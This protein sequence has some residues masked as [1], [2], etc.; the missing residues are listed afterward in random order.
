MTQTSAIVVLTG[1]GISRESGLGTFRDL[2][3]IWSRVRVEDVATPDAFIR[4]PARVH[5]F[6]N[7]RRRRIL[8][9]AVLPNAAHRALVRLEKAQDRRPGASFLLVTQNVDALHERAGSQHVLPMHGRLTEQSCTAC[10]MVAPCATDLATDMACPHCGQVGTPRPNIV[11]FGELP[12]HMAAIYEA[13]GACDLFVSIGTSGTIHPAAGFVA[14][15][16]LAGA[17]TVELNLEPSACRELFTETRYG[18]A[19]EI[20]PDFVDA[21]I[22][23]WE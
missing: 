22:Q 20:V 8:D 12:L 16:R 19:T 7:A 13:L 6:Y 15:A 14:E 2:D 17:R 4:D 11:W 18:P 1:A 23:S 10:G 5:A 9:P 3:G 21:L